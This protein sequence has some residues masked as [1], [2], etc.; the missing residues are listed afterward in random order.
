VEK[1]K[2]VPQP[3]MILASFRGLWARR[4][5]SLTLL[6]VA[7]RFASGE[8]KRALRFPAAAAQSAQLGIIPQCR[9]AFPGGPGGEGDA[10]RETGG[11]LPIQRHRRFTNDLAPPLP[12]HRVGVWRCSCR[13]TKLAPRD[14]RSHQAIG[15]RRPLRS[16][17]NHV[18]S[19]PVSTCGGCPRARCS[20]SI[21]TTRVIAL[22]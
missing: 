7:R 13:A 21:L 17:V 12:C 1:S 8:V 18:A 5:P 22:S 19:S 6:V 10:H 4:R 2:R 20:L 16:L 11:L 3:V 15:S 9:A 14:A